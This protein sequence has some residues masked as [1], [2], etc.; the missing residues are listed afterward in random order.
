RCLS[1][2]RAATLPGPPRLPSGQTR[3]PRLLCPP[4]RPTPPTP[5]SAPPTPPPPPALRQRLPAAPGL[6]TAAPSQPAT[7]N[8]GR[9]ATVSGQRGEVHA[10]LEVGQPGTHRQRV[11][12]A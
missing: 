2:A 1:A 9:I 5:A 4:Q 3:P 11:D 6:G 7:V 12:A 8:P 10:G